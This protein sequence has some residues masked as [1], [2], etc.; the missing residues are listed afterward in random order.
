M[1]FNKIKREGK[2]STRKRKVK[3]RVK[4]KNKMEGV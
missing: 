3:N 2:E 1:D 4:P